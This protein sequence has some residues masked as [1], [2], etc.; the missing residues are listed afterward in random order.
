VLTPSGETITTGNVTLPPPSIPKKPFLPVLTP[1]PVPETTPVQ[2]EEEVNETQSQVN[3]SES[4]VNESELNVTPS[5]PSIEIPTFTY[6]DVSYPEEVRPGETVNVKIS[7]KINFETEKSIISA[8]VPEGW[9]AESV[10]ASISNSTGNA[11]LKI[12]IPEGVEDG[13][14][15]VVLVIFTPVLKREQTLLFTVN[16]SR[17]EGVT[18]EEKISQKTGGNETEKPIS[19]GTVEQNESKKE[20]PSSYSG[21][22]T[23]G[24][25]LSI[26]LIALVLIAITRAIRL[27]K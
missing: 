6:M 22:Q 20:E 11:T 8:I 16:A 18:L 14:Y 21:E 10:S 2:E 15:S 12:D 4:Q 17:T 19:S 27:K 25:E 9:N 23:P 24:F 3:E 1:T 13:S 7:F 5:Q 26:A